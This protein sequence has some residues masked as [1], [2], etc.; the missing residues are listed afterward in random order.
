METPPPPLKGRDTVM[1][2]TY[3][4]GNIVARSSAVT[5][6]TWSL[7]STR[8]LVFRMQQA[9]AFQTTTY[10]SDWRLGVRATGCHELSYGAEIFSDIQHLQLRL[11]LYQV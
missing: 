9:R 3:N 1:H 5:S 8:G 6:L 4:L 11:T 2:P 7:L 10:S